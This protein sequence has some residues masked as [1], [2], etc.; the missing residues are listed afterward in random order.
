MSGHVDLGFPARD[1][2]NVWRQFRNALAHMAA[3]ESTVQ[4][5]GPTN[6]LRSFRKSIGGDWICNVDRLTVDLQRWLVGFA[7]KL[8]KKQTKIELAT[9]W[10]GSWTV[11]AHPSEAPTQA[12]HQR[13]FLSLT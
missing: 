13:P 2:E 1:A 4:T 5:G 8:N 10:T 12:R 7:K 11:R 9:R 3:P 6:E